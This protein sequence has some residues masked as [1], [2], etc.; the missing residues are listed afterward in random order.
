MCVVALALGLLSVS[1]RP[2]AD[3]AGAFDA[4]RPVEVTARVVGH[5]VWDGEG[6]SLPLR[7]L[8]VDQ[9]HPAAV[10][11]PARG[12]DLRLTLPGDKAPPA[13]GSRIVARGFLRR[14]AAY[15]NALPTPPGAWRLR[16]KSRRLLKIEAPPQAWAVIS[17]RWR[18]RVEEA[19]TSAGTSEADLAP[20]RPSRPGLAMVRALVLGDSNA[21]PERWKRGLRRAGLIHLLA[22]SGL[23]VGLVAGAVLLL[24]APLPA[25]LRPL[26]ALAAVLLYLVVV[27]PRPALLRASVMA[28]LAASA[29]MVRRPP[30]V[31]NAL[32]VTVAVLVLHRPALIDDLG[33]RLTASATAGLIFLT[34][35]WAAGILRCGGWLSQHVRRVGDLAAGQRL[36]RTEAGSDWGDGSRA[37]RWLTALGHLVGRGVAASLA[38]QLASAPFAWPIFHL[39]SLTSPLTNLVA[40][41]W[42]ALVLGVDLL[43]VGL[44]VL[45]PPT[46]SALLPVLDGLA[47]P[48]GWP[49]Q[50][51][52]GAWGVIP[53]VAPRIACW[54]AV[55]ALVV[56]ILRLGP[57]RWR[58]SQLRGGV[59]DGIIK[60]SEKR[61]RIIRAMP[62][63]FRLS[64]LPLLIFV[65]LPILRWGAVRGPAQ[66]A[67]VSVTLLDV[68]QGDAILLRD[69]ATSILVDGGGWR[70]GDF[71][72]RVLLPALLGEGV[73]RLDVVVLTHPD[74]DHCGGLV[75]VA[76]YLPVG[77]V[78]SALGWEADPCLRELIDSAVP[79][80]P[81]RWR[82]M[83]AG[84]AMQAGEWRFEVLHPP[85]PGVTARRRPSAR[86]DRSLV[87][88]AA[89]LGR[90][91]LLTGD[92]E[93]LA[94]GEILRRWSVEAAPNSLEVD[95]LKVAHHGSRSSTGPA[96]LRATQ[97]RVALISAGTANPYG[98]PAP[99][100][101]GRLEGAGATVLRTDLH[102][103]VRI[104]WD[105]GQG[106]RWKVG[107]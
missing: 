6:W 79:L 59:S 16:V 63:W 27:G 107:R 72:Q 10:A 61:W 100:I 9:G 26:P 36:R 77:E 69:G 80:R 46:A 29:V 21:V 54:I 31:G 86:N 94:E 42:T 23:H 20:G 50:G 45:S 12:A 28:G 22:V 14:S 106:W 105:D 17:H 74:R 60:G 40:V 62:S 30:L 34:P 8:R 71:G 68:G 102:G 99:E 78:W 66:P 3:L 88:L 18:L 92:V 39:T 82:R 24:A 76:S 67:G 58:M 38:A 7:V 19:I 47:A 98:H 96:W 55:L 51:D 1:V 15:A 43:W 35:V 84:D 75:D 70:R 90:R 53:M 33:F 25:R 5:G 101:L 89:A 32:A 49:S 4:A 56:P 97:P 64:V 41:P 91:V 2:A 57:W 103:F 95:L 65:L 104:E 13:L 87:L 93:A 37:A 11:Q 85:P 48:F 44:A 52:P 73:S 81:S 83:G